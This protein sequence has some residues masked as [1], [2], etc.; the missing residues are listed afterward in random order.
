M[1]RCISIILVALLLLSYICVGSPDV[2]AATKVT[3]SRAIAIVFDNSGSMYAQ[4]NQAWCRATYA[5]E[6]FASML[7]KGDVLKIY[8]MN[9]FTV[10]DQTYSMEEPFVITD[11]AQANL[12]REII[13]PGAGDTHI[14]SIDYADRKSVV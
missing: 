9:P 11:A 14:E 8:P 5:T 13:T 3:K 6:V 2:Y 1:R 4:S 10:G 12:I 7:N